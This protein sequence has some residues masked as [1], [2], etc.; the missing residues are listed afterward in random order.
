MASSFRNLRHGKFYYISPDLK[1]PLLLAKAGSQ[2][3]CWIMFRL[4]FSPL[5]C[6]WM[7][8]QLESTATGLTAKPLFRHW[9][10]CTRLGPVHKRSQEISQMYSESDADWKF[11]LVQQYSVERRLAI[12]TN[13]SPIVLDISAEHI[14]SSQWAAAQHL[15]QSDF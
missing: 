4:S 15:C 10:F 5:E 12:P 2:E 6:D 13:N 3:H 8:C 14:E 1:Y 7:Q 11:K 9:P